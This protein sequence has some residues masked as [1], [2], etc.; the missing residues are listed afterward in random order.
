MIELTFASTLPA[1]AATVWSAVSTMS[2]VNAELGPWIRMTSPR[3]LPA[4]DDASITPGVEVF[5]SWLL[6]GG[7]VPIDRHRLTLERVEPG[8]GFDEESHSWLQRRW[9][10]ERRV[11]PTDGGGCT[12][13]DRLVVEP[14]VRFMRPV[15]AAIVRQVF[16]H[17]HRR[18]R[19]RFG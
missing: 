19:R 10:H 1:S 8:V 18:L 3:D 6:V 14:R 11:V 15:V 2:G 5:A 4:L 9:R 17:R 13:T 16:A 12:V 7:V